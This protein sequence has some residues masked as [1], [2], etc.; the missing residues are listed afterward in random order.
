MADR[1]AA[2]KDGVVAFSRTG[3]PST[4]DYEDAVIIYRAGDVAGLDEDLA[5]AS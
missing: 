1:F 5:I 3:N 2:A 4:G